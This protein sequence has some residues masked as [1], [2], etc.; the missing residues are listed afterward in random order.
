MPKQAVARIATASTLVVTT[1]AALWAL[2]QYFRTDLAVDME[3]D[4]EVMEA[5]STALAR[6]HAN[7]Q[8]FGRDAYTVPG[9]TSI[10][11]TQLIEDYVQLVAYNQYHTR[12]A[13]L[14]A[15]P[16][17]HWQ[18]IRTEIGLI[19]DLALYGYQPSVIRRWALGLDG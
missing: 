1:A 4:G 13:L 8:F 6:F 15:T 10:E 14:M 7:A 12:F 9:A 11:Q 2:H 19:E 16:I 3:E 18:S 5:Q 17:K